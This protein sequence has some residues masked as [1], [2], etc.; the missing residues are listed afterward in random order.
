[1][2]VVIRINLVIISNEA[3]NYTEKQINF[4]HSN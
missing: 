3:M 1:M 2:N 4:I